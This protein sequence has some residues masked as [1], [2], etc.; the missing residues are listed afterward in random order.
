MINKIAL[1]KFLKNASKII[2]YVKCDKCDFGNG[3]T[4]YIECTITKRKD[5]KWDVTHDDHLMNGDVVEI[6]SSVAKFSEVVNMIICNFKN[7]N[8]NITKFFVD[9][10]DIDPNII[11]RMIM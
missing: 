5:N 8:T 3:P 11:V 10:K 6:A 2:F 4:D 7:N 1:S 9:D